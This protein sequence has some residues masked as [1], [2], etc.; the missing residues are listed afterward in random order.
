[1]STWNLGQAASSTLGAALLP[2]FGVAKGAYDG[3]PAL[4]LLR[5]ASMLLPLALIPHLLAPLH[6]HKA[7]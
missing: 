3:L 5:S 4:L 2:L 6:A 1:M 7:D